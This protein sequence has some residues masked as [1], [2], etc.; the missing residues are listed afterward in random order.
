M[1]DWYYVDFFVPA[2]RGTNV[3]AYLNVSV[4]FTVLLTT[5]LI[6]W[7]TFMTNKGFKNFF[8]FSFPVI[9]LA[10]QR[11]PTALSWRKASK[12]LFLISSPCKRPS[13]VCFNLVPSAS[14]CYKRKA[15]VLF[16]KIA[17]GV[18][19]QLLYHFLA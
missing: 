18:K 10:L 1:L 9:N 17:L 4:N 13:T 5:K 6:A 15:K 19:E 14:F 7:Q 2:A 16:F 8:F 11:F 3:V 12:S